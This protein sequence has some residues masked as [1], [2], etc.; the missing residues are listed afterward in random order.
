[1]PSRA[2]RL[3]VL[4]A[5][6]VSLG[7][8][9]AAI[10]AFA[11]AKMAVAFARQDTVAVSI[12][13]T[14]DGRHACPICVSLK[15]AAPSESLIAAPIHSRLAFVAPTAAPRAERV[16]VV[17]DVAALAPIPVVR[18]SRPSSPPPKAVLS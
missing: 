4:G 6:L 17:W 15:K 1:M 16:S 10:Q 3:L 9:T 14:F 8:H 18:S 12:A 11:W 5:F 7:M 13:K 2:A